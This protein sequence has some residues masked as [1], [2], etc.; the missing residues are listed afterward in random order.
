MDYP[1]KPLAQFMDGPD[2]R[3]GCGVLV[4]CPNCGASG[5]AWFKNPI[6]GGPPVH[7]VQWDRTGE[8]LET[9]SLTPSFLMIGHFH[10]FIRNGLLCVDSTFQCTKGAS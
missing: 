9:L 4:D 1:L 6:D 8:T 2:D 10:S 3:K 5:S 7:P